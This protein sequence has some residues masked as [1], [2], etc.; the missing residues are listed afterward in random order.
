MGPGLLASSCPL[1]LS[2]RRLVHALGTVYEAPTFSQWDPAR[3]QRIWDS[4]SRMA[5]LRTPQV[6]TNK[7]S[8]DTQK[9][10]LEL[11]QA[12][13]TLRAEQERKR[14]AQ[15]STLGAEEQNQIRSSST[16]TSPYNQKLKRWDWRGDERTYNR[17]ITEVSQAT[18]HVVRYGSAEPTWFE[19]KKSSMKSKMTTV[20]ANNSL[21]LTLDGLR[22]QRRGMW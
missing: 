21:S 17:M 4:T 13:P 1:A 18:V 11:E 8:E 20:T 22:Q 19:H 14:A 5:E 15:N 6:T 3:R 10:N 2:A 16:R 9:Q 7:V 12:I